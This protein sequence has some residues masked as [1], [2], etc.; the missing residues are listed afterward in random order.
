MERWIMNKTKVRISPL[1]FDYREGIA[2]LVDQ[3][4]EENQIANLDCPDIG[5]FGPVA[6]KVA[7]LGV[8]GLLRPPKVEAIFPELYVT[9]GHL[10][11]LIQIH[12]SEYFGVMNVFVVLEDE[13]GNTL[14][15]DYAME[16]EV[17][18]NHWGYVPS[19][20]LPGGTT[21][22]VRAIAMDSLGGV[23]V[24]TERITLQNETHRWVR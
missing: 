16:A 8:P 21:V 6:T 15:S 17:V 19:A 20:P 23:G 24:Q 22:V 3:V 1:F 13:Q 11:G 5:D 9:D 12:T 10:D 14:E 2:E 7:E 18:E 4:C